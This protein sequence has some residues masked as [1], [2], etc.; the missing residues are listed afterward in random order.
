MTRITRQGI[1][2]D[3]LAFTSWAY[4]SGKWQTGLPLVDVFLMAYNKGGLQRR[5]TFWS[6]G[7]RQYASE[8]G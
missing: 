7:R 6:P 4:Q 3:R 1:T 5:P 8:W 2:I